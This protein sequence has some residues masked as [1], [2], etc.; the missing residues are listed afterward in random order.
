VPILVGST[1]LLGY[2]A[3]FVVEH[4]VREKMSVQEKKQQYYN[5]V[6]SQK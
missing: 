3:L 1:L 2:A 5:A 6:M 4:Y